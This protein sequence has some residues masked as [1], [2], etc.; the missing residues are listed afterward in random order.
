MDFL[1][2]ADDLTGAYDIAVNGK[3]Y[4]KSIKVVW[5]KREIS[6]AQEDL[7]ICT[8]SREKTGP[9]ARQLLKRISLTTQKK[10]SPNFIYMK[11][12]SLLRGNI[13][14]EIS[15]VD[16]VYD[17]DYIVIDL[18]Y[19][20]LGRVVSDG[21][22]YFNGEKIQDTDIVYD[23]N[24][25]KSTDF[26]LNALA[27]EFQGKIQC[28]K[29][30]DKVETESKILFFDTVKD[31]DFSNIIHKM[32]DGKSKILWV[33]SIGLYM[34]L[35]NAYY[36]P[37]KVLCIIGSVT[38]ISKNQIL[39]AES[40][41][42]TL[43]KV[44]QSNQSVEYYVRKILALMEKG[45]NVILYSDRIS[46]QSAQ[47]DSSLLGIDKICRCIYKISKEVIERQNGINLIISGGETAMRLLSKKSISN[48]SIVGEIEKSVPIL[49]VQEGESKYSVIVK[50]GRV[51]DEQALIRY[52]KFMRMYANSI[53]A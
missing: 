19:P 34:G 29:H 27:Q 8:G 37:Q 30:N 7:I 13:V 28:L 21:E 5:K 25:Y 14:E 9:E 15:A 50:S 35:L 39:N 49:D 31:E 3:A 16:S 2:F 17:F 24:F 38:D 40:K 42:T 51:G 48:I 41:E 53:K 36:E 23:Y 10:C 52:I 4:N 45:K 47:R 22:V 6:D 18:A 11:V 20:S 32:N 33:G 12:D 26:F 1:I 44:E 46:I 43:V